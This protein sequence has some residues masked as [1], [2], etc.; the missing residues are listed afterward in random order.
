MRHSVGN[1]FVKAAE[2]G[3]H[4]TQNQ[5]LI[6]QKNPILIFHSLSN[7]IWNVSSKMSSDSTEHSNW[8]Q[9]KPDIAEPI[10]NGYININT[11][12]V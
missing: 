3:W 4:E 5:Y 7:I 9:H 2:Y 6:L 1:L 10:A 12:Y 8:S 11:V